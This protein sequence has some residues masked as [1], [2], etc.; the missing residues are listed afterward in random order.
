MREL[1]LSIPPWVVACGGIAMVAGLCGLVVMLLRRKWSIPLFQVGTI[2]VLLRDTWFV[3]DGRI[4]E[5]ASAPGLG[6]SILALLLFV[7]QLAL[8]M[9]GAR[10]G[11]LR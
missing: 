1:Y 11:W 3:A 2:G 9:Y 5:A 7:F 10:R 4:W 6:L 8:A